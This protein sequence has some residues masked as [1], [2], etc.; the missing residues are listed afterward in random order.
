MKLAK[1]NQEHGH[2]ELAV[3]G[4]A[5]MEMRQALARKFAAHTHSEG[6][7][8]TAI[9]GL[10]LFRHTVPSA[11]HAAMC[12]PS[13]SI[14][15]QGRKL[16]NLAGTEYLCD[17]SSFLVSSIDVPIQSQIL[18]AS[19]AV[20]FLAMRLRLDMTALQ[21]VL[22]REDLPEP[23]P[24]TA[25]GAGCARLEKASSQGRGLAVGETT[26][27]LLTATSRLLELLDSP[28]DI[29]FLAPLVQREI[30]YRILRT[31][32]GERLRAIATRGDLS[33]KTVRAIAWLR[34]NYTKPLR[35]EELAGIARMGVSTF[36]HQFRALTAMSPLQYQKQLRLQAARQ[37]MLTDGI[38]ATN[39]A[40]EVG[41]ESVS[42][43]SREYSRFFGQPPMRDVRTLRL[44]GAQALHLETAQ[45]PQFGKQDHARN[46]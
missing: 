42:Q 20:P 21:E 6:E 22:S 24:R 30:A 18:E 8:P 44:A 12:E 37:R 33:N 35:M 38:D 7:H 16:I 19:E 36:H 9:S 15:V 2:P 39:A 43:F 28:E 32:Q 4:L 31:P 45:R 17:G 10:V 5:A 27:G 11:C 25:F 23:E 34:A 26:V 3:P 14:F 13:F 41:Y 29:P 46:H 40:Y 1:H